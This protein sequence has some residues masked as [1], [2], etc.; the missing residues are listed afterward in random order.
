MNIETLKRGDIVR[1][2]IPAARPIKTLDGNLHEAGQDYKVL[3]LQGTSA[4]W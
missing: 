4:P 2:V 1:L 3:G